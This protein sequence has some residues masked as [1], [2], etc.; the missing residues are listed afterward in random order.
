[1]PAPSNDEPHP[2]LPN[3]DPS[4]S[5]GDA[6]VG[7]NDAPLTEDMNGNGIS[8]PNEPILPIINVKL[9]DTYVP[10]SEI[11]NLIN[12]D[13]KI[14]NGRLLLGGLQAGSYVLAITPPSGFSISTSDD[15]FSGLKPNANG[16]I[17]VRFT[18]TAKEK[19]NL[20]ISFWRESRISG[21]IRLD[22]SNNKQYSHSLYEPEQM[23]HA[24]NITVNLL[25]HGKIITSTVTDANGNYSFA[26][27]RPSEYELQVVRDANLTLVLERNEHTP[28]NSTLSPSGALR[29]ATTSGERATGLNL[30]LVSAKVNQR[31]Y[32][33]LLPVLVNHEK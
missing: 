33:V 23:A 27:L 20:A 28:S 16:D 3:V 13:L 2:P 19:N 5:Q 4:E 14:V 17:L 1:M 32:Q 30:R 9:F 26:G 10:N 25:R 7:A 8:E 21:H 12:A 29:L 22:L 18:V 31:N 15:D 6:V 11:G 24:A